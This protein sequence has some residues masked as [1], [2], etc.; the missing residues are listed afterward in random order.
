MADFLKAI[1]DGLRGDERWLPYEK[2]LSRA[3]AAIAAYAKRHAHIVDHLLWKLVIGE[4]SREVELVLGNNTSPPRRVALLVDEGEVSVGGEVRRVRVSGRVCLVTD[5]GGGD[6]RGE[7][8]RFVTAEEFEEWLASETGARAKELYT[9]RRGV[10]YATAVSR[11]VGDVEAAADATRA[12]DRAIGPHH[13]QHDE[14]CQCSRCEYGVDAIK[15]LA[16][17]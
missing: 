1:E 16:D 14:A 3:N 9:Y 12:A 10:P 2:V 11:W 13:P 6:A 8:R 7:S 5:H 15:G 17:R 4:G